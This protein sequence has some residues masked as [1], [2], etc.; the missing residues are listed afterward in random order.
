MRRRA[1]KQRL[2]WSFS[3]AKT[4]PAS[5]PVAVDLLR[6]QAAYNDLSLVWEWASAHKKAP[7][8]PLA[9]KV[10]N[11]RSFLQLR[12]LAATIWEALKVV[13]EM[14]KLPGFQRLKEKMDAVGC[15]NLK[16]LQRVLSGRHPLSKIFLATTRNKTTYHYDRKEFKNGLRRLLGRY[17]KDSESDILSVEGANVEEHFHFELPDEIRAELVAGTTGA[18]VDQLLENLLDLSTTFG[19][20]AERLCAAYCK[21]RGMEINFGRAT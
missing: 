13:E 15:R 2:A 14:E 18:D 20:F 3:I 4:F 16:R 8:D 6:L 12:L 11:S 17:G 19:T 5:D 7:K 9:T 1:S 21:D 10:A